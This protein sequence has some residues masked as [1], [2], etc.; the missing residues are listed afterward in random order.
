MNLRVQ[1]EIWTYRKRKRFRR[2]EFREPCEEKRGCRRPSRKFHRQIHGLPEVW[3]E[4]PRRSSPLMSDDFLLLFDCDGRL[5]LSNGRGDYSVH[6]AFEQLPD[7]NLFR[8]RKCPSHIF[9]SRF[10]ISFIFKLGCIYSVRVRPYKFN[11]VFKVILA[12][13]PY[14][15]KVHKNGLHSEKPISSWAYFQ[16][17]S[18]SSPW[19]LY[20]QKLL[21]CT[22]LPTRNCVEL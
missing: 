19:V 14:K 8:L 5:S 13:Q 10:K 7:L 17:C 21:Q 15:F 18:P 20:A 2:W 4:P 12:R 6:T 16:D 9:D 1:L 22:C 3:R 11:H